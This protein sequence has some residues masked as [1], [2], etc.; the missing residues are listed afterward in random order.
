MHPASFIQN[1]NHIRTMAIHETSMNSSTTPSGSQTTQSKDSVL[2]SELFA[3]YS[4]GGWGKN[5]GEQQVEDSAALIQSVL[6]AL[7]TESDLVEYWKVE[8]EGELPDWMWKSLTSPGANNQDDLSVLSKAYSPEL[9]EY[10][11][12]MGT[13]LLAV[14][15]PKLSPFEI[16]SIAT[17]SSVFSDGSKA[18]WILCLLVASFSLRQCPSPLEQRWKRWQSLTCETIRLFQNNGIET[19]Y[20]ALSLWTHHIVPSCQHVIRQLPPEALHLGLLSGMVGTTSSLVMKECDRLDQVHQTVVLSRGL[21]L[22]K[23]LRDIVQSVAIQGDIS[24]N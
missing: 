13:Q 5:N 3:N 18:H 4:D 10:E 11:W 12:W 19:G 21:L 8:T 9:V 24:E 23:S 2:P 6:S 1:K 15:L 16:H 20:H 7:A 17:D 22:L 14:L